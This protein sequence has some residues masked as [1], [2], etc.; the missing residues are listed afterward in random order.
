VGEGAGA[1]CWVSQIGNAWSSV[2]Q[3]LGPTTE[4]WIRDV[5]K[6]NDNAVELRLRSH[7]THNTLVQVK[8]LRGRVQ[9]VEKVKVS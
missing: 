7:G 2:S 8:E 9:L 1:F 4:D 6:I 5:H 3:L